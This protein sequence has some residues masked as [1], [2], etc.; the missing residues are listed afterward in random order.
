MHNAKL[1]RKP[2]YFNF[3]YI[4]KVRSYEELDIRLEEAS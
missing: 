1:V 4:L 2:N 3:K